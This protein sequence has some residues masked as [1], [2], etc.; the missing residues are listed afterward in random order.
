MIRR[1][2][3]LAALC[4]PA[5][6]ALACGEPSHV[7]EGR[8]FLPHRGCL[9]T[10]SSVDVVDGEPPGDCGPTCLAQTLPD[11][12][13]SIYVATMCPPYPF[14]FDVSG[15]DPRCPEALAALSRDDTCLVDGGSTHPPPADAAAD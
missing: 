13:A 12:G 5:L 15:T 11:G 4:A 10:T 7:F 8:L 2:A 6:A 9:G 14:A 3:L 1:L